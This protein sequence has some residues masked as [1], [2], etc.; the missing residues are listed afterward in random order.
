[1]YC[2]VVTFFVVVVVLLQAVGDIRKTLERVFSYLGQLS[3][4]MWL[5]VW[6]SSMTVNNIRC[7]LSL[8]VTQ[9]IWHNYQSPEFAS[10][11]TVFVSW[12]C[13]DVA[14]VQNTK[15]MGTVQM[16]SIFPWFM[17]DKPPFSLLSLNLS[18]LSQGY[19]S[20]CLELCWSRAFQVKTVWQ[21]ICEELESPKGHNHKQKA[22]FYAQGLVCLCEPLA[23]YTF[24]TQNVADLFC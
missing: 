3:L 18:C 12:Q 2:L 1:M 17:L 6:C 21:C 4:C 10:V 11:K 7:F 16:V 22:N 15:G 8:F 5:C 24:Y 14:G 9:F 19:Y 23:L 13:S 20:F